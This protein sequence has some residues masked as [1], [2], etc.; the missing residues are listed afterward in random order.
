MGNQMGYA[1]QNGGTHTFAS[2][3]NICGINNVLKN[4]DNVSHQPKT[5]ETIERDSIN[6]HNSPSDPSLDKNG[7]HYKF[8]WNPLH[9]RLPVFLERLSDEL[10]LSNPHKHGHHDSLQAQAVS[11]KQ[12]IS[13]TLNSGLI[14]FTQQECKA[15]RRT[16]GCIIRSPQNIG[17]EVFLLIF[18][19]NPAIKNIFP[20]FGEKNLE[21]IVKDPIFRAHSKR[22]I[23]SIRSLVENLQDL[24]SV[25]T[26]MEALGKLH[27]KFPG[28]KPEY[29]ILFK[30]CIM[31]VWKKEIGDEFTPEVQ[32]AWDLILNLMIIKM[33]EGY[34]SKN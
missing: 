26:V 14:S 11:N 4:D 15:I 21:D 12:D 28:F 27:Q 5:I 29:W 13:D 33:K 31:E 9:V 22:F 10:S 2:S 7:P 18:K 8:N 20:S 17:I 23:F 32:S 6:G 34:E 19:R 3:P 16:W 1:H 25:T 24:K 30:D